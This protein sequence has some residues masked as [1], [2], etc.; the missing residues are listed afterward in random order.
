LI[1]QLSIQKE[2]SKIGGYGCSAFVNLLFHRFGIFSFAGLQQAPDFDEEKY[3]NEV[4]KGNL[5]AEKDFSLPWSYTGCTEDSSCLSMLDEFL[6]TII[7]LITELPPPPPGNKFDQVCQ[8]KKRLRREVVHRLVSG[9][10]THSELAEVHHVLP[11]RDT[12]SKICN[13]LICFLFLLS[14]M[15]GHCM[16][17]TC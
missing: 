9:P 11:H 1:G 3:W 5:C 4:E 13:F 16:Y 6:Y 2:E 17:R 10:K 8:A 14:H 7:M 15:K 12:V